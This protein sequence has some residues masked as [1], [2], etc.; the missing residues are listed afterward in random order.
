MQTKRLIDIPHRPS[1][2]TFAAVLAATLIIVAAALAFKML[3][4]QAQ[5]ADPPAEPTGLSASGV[6]SD[7]VTL[8]WDD[9]GDNSITGHQVLRRF[10]DGD[11]YGDGG[12]AAEFAVI[13]DDTGSAAATYTDASVTPRTRYVYRVKAINPAGTSGQSSYLNVE[14]LA[15][16]EVPEAPMGLSAPSATHESVTLNWDD[17][18][19]SSITG[20]QVLRRFRDGDEY[21]DGEGAAEF[22]VIEENTGS[23]ATTYTDTSVTARTRYAYSVKAI[24]AAGTSGQS[25]HLDVE[26]P[27]APPDRPLSP[28]RGS[29]PNVVLILADDLGWGDVETNNPDSA[30]TT[31]RIDGIAAA[32]VNFTDAHS[33]SS[34]CTGTRYGLLTGRYSWRSWMGPGVLNGYD[35]PLIGPDRSTLGTLL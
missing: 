20:H 4:A 23:A 22:A 8:N 18:G 13:A 1:R 7:S 31:P 14:T 29:R 28:A 6:S 3:P 21:G 5:A 35:R 16:A 10:R 11:E 24:S 30:M 33:P 17:P 32:G 25:G 9:P 2:K 19:D 34:N 12:G 27:E 15:V 26:T